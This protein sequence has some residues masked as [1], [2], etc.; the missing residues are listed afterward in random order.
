MTWP[1]ADGFVCDLHGVSDTFNPR[2][3]RHASPLSVAFPAARSRRGLSSL[4]VL[5]LV[6]RAVGRA[7]RPQ[8]SCTSSIRDRVT[9]P[10]EQKCLCDALLHISCHRACRPVKHPWRD[11]LQRNLNQGCLLSPDL[12]SWAR[13]K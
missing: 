10:A 8:S 4:V 9:S 12:A 7:G 11:A 6:A 2:P 1:Y 3:R 5:M 13:R